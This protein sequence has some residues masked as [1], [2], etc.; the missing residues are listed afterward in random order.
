MVFFKGRDADAVSQAFREF[1]YG[2]EKKKGRV[3]LREKLNHFKD[4]V[5]QDRNRERS[6]EKNK[7]R[8]QSL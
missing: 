4:A 8:G 2:N 7:D 5:S 1:V 6:R 3:S